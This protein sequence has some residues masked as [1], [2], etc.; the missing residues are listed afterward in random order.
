MVAWLQAGSGW[1]AGWL[2]YMRQLN[3][4]HKQQW[5]Q[6]EQQQQA[7]QQALSAAYKQLDEAATPMTAMPAVLE[8]RRRFTA[9]LAATALGAERTARSDQ[10]RSPNGCGRARGPPPS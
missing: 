1:L 10:I 8:A 2:A 3:Q 6:P 9:S 4:Q 5:Q 7:A